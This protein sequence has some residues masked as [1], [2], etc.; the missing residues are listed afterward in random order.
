MRSLTLRYAT[1]SIAF[2][3]SAA[4]AFC[5]SDSLALSS[6]ATVPGGTVSLNL[7]LSSSSGSQPAGIEWTFAYSTSDVVANSI[8]AVA[9]AA[10]TAAGKSLWCAG[11][12]GSYTCFL[13]GLGP[14]GLNTN[15]IQNGV[16]AVLTVTISAATSWTSIGITNALS[17]SVAGDAIQTTATGGAIFVITKVSSLSCN[18][19]SLISGSSGICTVQLSRNVVY[20]QTVQL[21]ANS[22]LLTI[23][24]SVLV[25]G[26][27][28]PPP[29]S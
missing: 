16:I 12:P 27:P 10:A 18:P 3:M 7:S 24:V 28:L 8:S 1:A 9:G 25:P 2:F 20:S 6:G 4:A 17:T 13:T 14:G 11:I 22:L 5:Q 21:T 19:T 29:S 26:G 15:I 23:P